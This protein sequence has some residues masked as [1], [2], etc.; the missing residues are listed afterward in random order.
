MTR[1]AKNT[2]CIFLVNEKNLHPPTRPN[3]IF[4][5]RYIAE[6]A[7][8]A[9]QRYFFGLPVNEDKLQKIF[10]RYG[11]QLAEHVSNLLRLRNLHVL[12]IKQ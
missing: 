3:F 10:E 2:S 12:P 7:W 5:E 9:N 1:F 8:A 4:A 11:G 6:R